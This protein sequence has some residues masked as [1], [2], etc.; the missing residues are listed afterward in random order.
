MP[1]RS[2]YRP[3]N[4][5]SQPYNDG[6]AYFYEQ[7]N[8]ADDGDKPELQATLK[9]KLPFENQRLGINRL[10]LSRQHQAE[11]VKVIRVARRNI[12]PQDLVI[13]DDGKQYLIDSVQDVTDILPPSVDVALRRYEEKVEVIPK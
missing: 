1:H 4:D 7:Q 9:G 10:Y 8:I 13:L 3:T 5:V 6:V 11:I 12:S 2:P